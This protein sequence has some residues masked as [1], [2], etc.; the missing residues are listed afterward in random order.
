MKNWVKE[1]V[2]PEPGSHK[3]QNGKLLII[4]GSELFHAPVLWAAEVAS[5]MVDMIHVT[6]PYR[7]NNQLMEY[8]LKQKFWNGIVVDWE[9]A[10]D[11]V[12]EDEVVLIGPGM[13]RT[14]Q[15]AE[16]TNQ[17][18]VKFPKKR[19]VVDGGALQMVDPRLLNENMIITPHHKEWERLLQLNSNDKFQM[20]NSTEQVKHFS[21][22]HNN[23]TILL[24][25]R[26][27]IVVRGEQLVEVSGGNEGM[28]KGGTGDVL[29]GLVAALATKNELLTAA[30]AASQINKTA[31]EALE[32]RVGRWFNATD[33]VGQIPA[34]MKALAE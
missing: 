16:I 31:A 34:T 8:Q 10:A 11:Y 22:Q 15:T 20:S 29:A 9:R 26:V 3:G 33:L 14:A 2:K 25:G 18:L 30:A 7:L 19:W 23:V 5:R 1:L 21:M 4:G 28:T 27:D 17:W 6:S 24:K 13:T 12:A 32:Q